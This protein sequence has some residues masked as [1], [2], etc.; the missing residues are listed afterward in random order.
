MAGVHCCMTPQPWPR[1]G[2]GAATDG[3]PKFDLD[4]FDPG[5]F[6]RLRERVVAPGERGIYVSVMLF[7]GFSAQ[8]TTTRSCRSSRACR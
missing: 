1:T 3:K 4:R 7:E 5:F 6:D 2:P 8:S